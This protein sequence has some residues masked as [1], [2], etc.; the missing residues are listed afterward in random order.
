MVTTA[1]GFDA[2]ARRPA[3]GSLCGVPESA[4]I[5][6]RSFAWSILVHPMKV[7]ISDDLR[8]DGRS[9]HWA[10]GNATLDS[11]HLE[12]WGPPPATKRTMAT[13]RIHGSSGSRVGFPVALS[14]HAS[15]AGAA[16]PGARR[17]RLSV[18]PNPSVAPSTTWCL[19]K[20]FGTK[21]TEA[22]RQLVGRSSVDSR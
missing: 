7:R 16:D 14:H 3:K 12:N 8:T 15:E 20:A 13:A 2:S 5:R 9:C 6:A 22:F 17:E 11:K 1:P 4:A 18:G 19:K 10:I 21:P